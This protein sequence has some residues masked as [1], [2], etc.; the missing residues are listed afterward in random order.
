MDPFNTPRAQ[1]ILNRV[2]RYLGYEPGHL[3]P[4]VE[5]QV[6]D[7]VKTPKPGLSQVS[8]LDAVLDGLYHGVEM[9]LS[10]QE[11]DKCQS[12]PN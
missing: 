9:W 3:T 7:F 1:A 12:N 2:I 6:M 10:F 11:Y 5:G 4:E 8:I